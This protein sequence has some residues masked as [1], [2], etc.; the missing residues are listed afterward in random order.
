MKLTKGTKPTIGL[1]PAFKDT[2]YKHFRLEN[3]EQYETDDTALIAY[4]RTKGFS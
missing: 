1:P 2:T 3:Y 4:L